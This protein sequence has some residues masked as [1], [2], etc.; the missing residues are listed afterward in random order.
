MF[1][2][3]ARHAAP[4]AALMFTSG[5]ESGEAHG[6]FEGEALFHDSLSLAQYQDL[7]AAHR[8]EVVAHMA[9]DPDCS[10]HTTWLAG[11]VQS[12]P[13]CSQQARSSV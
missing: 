6:S 10:G 13:S 3:F 1:A 4:G 12:E 8:L 2:V 11:Q 5:S 7:L 9:E